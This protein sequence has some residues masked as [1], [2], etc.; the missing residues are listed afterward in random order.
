MKFN[1]FI[2]EGKVLTILQNSQSKVDTTFY[3]IEIKINLKYLFQNIY[4]YTLNIVGR[5][6]ILTISVFFV[7]TLIVSNI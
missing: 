4:I 1:P 7:V 2:L 5:H 3:N 6:H